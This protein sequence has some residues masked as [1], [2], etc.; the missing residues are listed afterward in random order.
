[1]PD[2]RISYIPPGQGRISA[3]L[4]LTDEEMVE[5]VAGR[6][7]PEEYGDELEWDED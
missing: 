7:L 4:R 3:T 1:M 5:F 2:L 6:G